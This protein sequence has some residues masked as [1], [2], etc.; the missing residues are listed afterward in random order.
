MK[1]IA[2]ISRDGVI[3]AGGRIPWHV[4]SEMDYF[5]NKT[6][7]NTVIMGRATKDTL[8]APLRS[9][10]NV[11]MTRKTSG[12]SGYVYCNSTEEAIKLYPNA[13]VIGGAQIYNELLPYCTELYLSIIP[14]DVTPGMFRGEFT[15]FPFAQLQG[16]ERADTEYHDEFVVGIYRNKSLITDKGE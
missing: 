1:A 2:A 11:V 4:S 14:I 6:W 5:K 12:C 15:S 16:W 7:N 10:Q 8:K 9:R 13:F 3:G